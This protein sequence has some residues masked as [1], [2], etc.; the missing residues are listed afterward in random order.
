MNLI[1]FDLGRTAT[2][3]WPFVLGMLWVAVFEGATFVLRNRSRALVARLI[4]LVGGT[5][6]VIYGFIHLIALSD[7]PQ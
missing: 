2:A 1:A 5:L 4:S 6:W 7:W 3:I